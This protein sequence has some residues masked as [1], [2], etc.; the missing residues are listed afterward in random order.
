MRDPFGEGVCRL[1]AGDSPTIAGT[2]SGLS[3][4]ERIAGADIDFDASDRARTVTARGAS[5]VRP[6]SVL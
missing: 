1:G 6:V 4:T 5:D 3:R 2:S